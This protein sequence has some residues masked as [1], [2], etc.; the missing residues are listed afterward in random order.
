MNDLFR[1]VMVLVAVSILAVVALGDLGM[2]HPISDDSLSPTYDGIDE[3]RLIE[4]LSSAPTFNT[5]TTSMNFRPLDEAIIESLFAGRLNE[6]EFPCDVRVETWDQG[7]YSQPGTLEAIVM[8][9]D[10]KQSHAAG[11]N[12]IWLIAY[13]DGWVLDRMIAESD[14]VYYDVMDLDNDGTLEIWCHS[15]WGNQGYDHSLSEIISV[16]LN[17]LRTMYQC[18]GHNNRGAGEPDEQGYMAIS[19]SLEFWDLDG[20]SIFEII[21]TERRH[22]W[23]SKGI[24]DSQLLST[25]TTISLLRLVG[26]KYELQNQGHARTY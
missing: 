16:D 3:M 22:T 26:Q 2:N 8:I 25:E 7:A 20:D 5:W 18:E 23:G 1:V 9:H 17:D 24:N 21:D 12:E 11:A 6:D 14:F 15:N 10:W 4:L 13:E 19:H